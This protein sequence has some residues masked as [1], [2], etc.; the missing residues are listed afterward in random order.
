MLSV[1]CPTSFIAAKTVGLL[2]RDYR[3]IDGHVKALKEE[4]AATTDFGPMSGK[5]EYDG[6][7]TREPGSGN[8]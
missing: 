8:F 3:S 2:T 7:V 4:A 5:T 6:R 1:L